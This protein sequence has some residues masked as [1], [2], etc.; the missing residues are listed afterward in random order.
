M[1]KQGSCL[2]QNWLYAEQSRT[3]TLVKSA[4]IGVGL[5]KDDK[6]FEKEK[7][8][9]YFESCRRENYCKV[10]EEPSAQNAQPLK[11]LQ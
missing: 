2:H 11:R 6:K 9:H 3:D 10:Q 8:G 1:S 7:G 4:V 5:A